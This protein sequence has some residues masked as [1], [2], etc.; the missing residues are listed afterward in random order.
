V[1]SRQGSP[2]LQAQI[3]INQARLSAL[4]AEMRTLDQSLAV[5]K[6]RHDTTQAELN[7]IQ[8][9]MGKAG[10]S[11]PSCSQPDV[12]RRIQALC[13]QYNGRVAAY[14]ALVE[15]HNGIVSRR[16]QLADEHDRVVATTN[17]LI[18]ALNW[19]R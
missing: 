17:T 2:L 11:P 4:T 7:A 8:A 15:Q 9:E 12:T 1:P 18:E 10:A 14:N 3:D 5:L 13:Q 16:G 19:T 6:R